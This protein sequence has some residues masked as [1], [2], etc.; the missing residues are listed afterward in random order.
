[1][2]KK[3]ASEWGFLPLIFFMLF[4]FFGCRFTAPQFWYCQHLNYTNSIETPFCIEPPQPTQPTE[5]KTPM[6]DMVSLESCS[7]GV[8]ETPIY[9]LSLGNEQSGSLSGSGSGHF[10]GTFLFGSGYESS[11]ISGETHTTQYYYYYTDAA[12]GLVLSK[13]D[14][15]TTQIFMTDASEPMLLTVG[16]NDTR[17]VAG[18]YMYSI[19]GFRSGSGQ[20]DIPLSDFLVMNSTAC[21]DESPQMVVSNYEKLNLTGVRSGEKILVVPEGAIKQEYKVN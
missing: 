12:H 5:Q 14:A 21:F 15:A 13:A 7:Y 19:N 2:G 1:M 20:K 8:I 9:S 11:S 17:H 4:L 18:G 6:L 10:S 16:R 3:A